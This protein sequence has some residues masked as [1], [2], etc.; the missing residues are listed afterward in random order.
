[1]LLVLCACL[2]VF[3]KSIHKIP[4]IIDSAKIE[5]TSLRIETT[6]GPTVSVLL[7]IQMVIIPF[8]NYEYERSEEAIAERI[9]DYKLS[10]KKNLHGSSSC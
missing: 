8:Q 5:V 2:L 9:A 3:F 7:L 1:M 6:P 4:I 10:L